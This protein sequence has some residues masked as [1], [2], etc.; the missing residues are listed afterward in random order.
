MSTVRHSGLRPQNSVEY[1]VNDSDTLE[2]IAAKYDCTPSELM[3]LN[4]LHSR[5][6]FSGQKIYVP[7]AGD[8]D[9]CFEAASDKVKLFNN[10]R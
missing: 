7:G 4:R 2:R 5:M 6:V 3:K 8:E 1:V 10:G 9:S